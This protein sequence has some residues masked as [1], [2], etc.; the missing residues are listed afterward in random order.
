MNLYIQ[1]RGSLTLGSSILPVKVK[2]YLMIFD[3]YV[4]AGKVGH[5]GLRC[6]WKDGKMAS[7]TSDLTWLV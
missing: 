4:V 2:R 7:Y 6:L 5:S 1:V 3:W